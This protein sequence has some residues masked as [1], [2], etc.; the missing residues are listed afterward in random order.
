MKLRSQLDLGSGVSL[1]T[2]ARLV[3]SLPNPPVKTYVDADA[4][5]AWQVGVAIEL[6][7]T[8]TNLL[9]K[10]RDES[11]DASRGQLVRRSIMAGTRARF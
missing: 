5:L 6:Y 1:D 4:R 8:G 3:D 2:Q 10:T 9:H 7:L 11:N